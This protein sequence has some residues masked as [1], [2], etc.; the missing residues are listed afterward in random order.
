MTTT[1][2]I[3]ELRALRHRNAELEAQIVAMRARLAELDDGCSR[4]P[5][6]RPRVHRPPEPREHV[7]TDVRPRVGAG[8]VCDMYARLVLSHHV[9]ELDKPRTISAL[10]VEL[11][12]RPVS[13]DREL[14]LEAL[15]ELTAMRLIACDITVGGVGG[16]IAIRWVELPK[17][18]TI[19]A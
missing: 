6:V 15:E 11:G 9:G 19:G 10:A 5:P 18:R 16:M 1:T 12:M 13:E 14:M 7:V 4:L 17:I 8:V 2:Q 3:A